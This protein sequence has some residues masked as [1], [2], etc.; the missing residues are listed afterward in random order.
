MS[1]GWV[2]EHRSVWHHPLFEGYEYSPREAWLW[3]IQEA[4]HEPTQKRVGQDI[5]TLS[6]GQLTVSVRYLAERWKWSKSRVSRFLGVLKKRDMIGTEGGTA[7]SI[8]TICNYSDYQSREEPIGTPRDAQPGQLRDSCGTKDKNSR[9]QEINNTPLTP[10]AG[11]ADAD[12]GFPKVREGRGKPGYVPRPPSQAQRG[13]YERFMAV[14]Q[15]QQDVEKG[16]A[17]FRCFCDAD[18]EDLIWAGEQ[19]IRWMDSIGREYRFCPKAMNFLHR[20]PSQRAEH[21]D[22]ARFITP[23]AEAKDATHRRQNNMGAPS[24]D[25]GY[26]QGDVLGQGARVRRGLPENAPVP[27]ARQHERSGHAGD[28]SMAWLLHP[29]SG[30]G[31]L[32]G[33]GCDG[34]F[35]AQPGREPMDVSRTMAKRDDGQHERRLPPD[36]RH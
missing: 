22:W 12:T 20:D 11:G 36:T 31:E 25:G 1:G 2:K 24:Q 4:A 32:P 27:G 30:R 16:Y 28:E 13:R 18:Q 3:L 15:N 14:W 10:P 9:T 33:E 23:T 35:A 17:K 6:R 5:I 29:R 8:I 19:Y 21:G 34:L 26:D 7:Q